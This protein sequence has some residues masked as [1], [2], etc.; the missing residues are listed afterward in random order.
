MAFRE[1]EDTR[2]ATASSAKRGAAPIVRDE[3]DVADEDDE[4]MV[5]V[6]RKEAMQTVKQGLRDAYLI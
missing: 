2:A 4:E 5:V 3:S 6:E 1:V